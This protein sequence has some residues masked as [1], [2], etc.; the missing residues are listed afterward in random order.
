MERFI[1]VIILLMI[2]TVPAAAPRDFAA[3]PTLCFNAGATTFALSPTASTPDYRVKFIP[4]EA[5]PD[6]RIQL[7]DDVAGADFALVDDFAPMP[8]NPCRSA[9][10]HT[11]IRIV[12]EAAPADVSI[13]L[14]RREADYKIFVHSAR[15]GHRDAAAL[16]AAVL[17]YQDGGPAGEHN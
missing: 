6:L 9:G 17:H 11:T 16:F 8:G 12:G 7:I 10:P 5:K 2:A 15:F 4:V 3:S 1:K 14:S 13:S